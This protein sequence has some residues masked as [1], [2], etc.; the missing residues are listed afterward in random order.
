MNKYQ[1]T[2]RIAQLYLVLQF[3]SERMKTFTVGERICIN[4]ERFQWMHIL[5]NSAAAPRPV[6][7]AIENKIKEASRLIMQNH[8]KPY[9]SDPFMDETEI[10]MT[11]KNQ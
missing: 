8:F 4:Q 11:L 3:C 1:I 5:E 10:N 9:Y 2:E 6:S 7:S